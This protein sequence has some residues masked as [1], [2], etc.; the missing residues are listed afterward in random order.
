MSYL[1]MLFGRCISFRKTGHLLSGTETWMPFWMLTSPTATDGLKELVKMAHICCGDP[2]DP[3][4]WHP[5][6]FFSCGGTMSTT[7]TYSPTFTGPEHSEEVN[8]DVSTS[9]PPDMLQIW[10]E[11]DCPIDMYHVTMGSLSS[12]NGMPNTENFSTKQHTLSPCSC[13]PIEDS[14]KYKGT[15]AKHCISWSTNASI[16]DVSKNTALIFYLICHIFL[17][18]SI[19]IRATF[20]SHACTRKKY[21]SIPAQ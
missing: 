8:P 4:N 6:I 5:V 3:I 18:L 21:L 15:C 2:L 11:L 1:Y 12:L 17:T 10:E 14:G 13:L 19:F 7:F 16:S 20:L 9:V